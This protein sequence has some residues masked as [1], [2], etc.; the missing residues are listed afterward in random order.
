MS[1]MWGLWIKLGP[2]WVN[3]FLPPHPPIHDPLHGNGSIPE[4]RP[5]TVRTTRD[6]GVS[7]L[8]SIW[9]W[10]L[11]GVRCE[12]V[13]CIQTKSVL[14]HV[15]CTL[16]SYS[17]QEWVAPEDP[18]SSAVVPLKPVEF[19]C[20]SQNCVLDLMGGKKTHMTKVSDLTEFIQ[21]NFY[22]IF[23]LFKIHIHI[24]LGIE[25]SL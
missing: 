9:R 19:C 6:V 12:E 4:P 2:R 1:L 10:W 16:A 7:T 14:L 13:F 24:K 23:V 25:S 3:C 5:T 22:N 17:I 18:L 11:G 15:C 8:W 20:Q 21:H